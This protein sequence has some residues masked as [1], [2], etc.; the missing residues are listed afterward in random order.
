M[1]MKVVDEK[2]GV[3]A[4]NKDLAKLQE[5]FRRVVTKPI[6]QEK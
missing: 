5:Q 4:I 2:G 6:S 1:N 3:L